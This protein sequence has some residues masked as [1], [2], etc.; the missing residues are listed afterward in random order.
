MIGKS[1]DIDYFKGLS[2]KKLKEIIKILKAQLPREERTV[3]TYSKNFT[4]SL[5]NYCQKQKT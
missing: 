2:I 3:I 1:K 5:S 4:L